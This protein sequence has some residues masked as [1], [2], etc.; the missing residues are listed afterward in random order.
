MHYK[1][2]VFFLVFQEITATIGARKPV[3]TVLNFVALTNFAVEKAL[4]NTV[5]MESKEVMITTSAL[6]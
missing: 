5:V 6:K 1:N 3:A 4:L 2:S